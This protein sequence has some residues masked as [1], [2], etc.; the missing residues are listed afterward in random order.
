MLLK[1]SSVNQNVLFILSIQL[2]VTITVHYFSR[3]EKLR[4]FHG[5]SKTVVCVW[6]WD[7][8]W[9][10]NEA[11]QEHGPSCAKQNITRIKQIKNRERNR[12]LK[13]FRI[14]SSTKETHSIRSII[15]IQ[16]KSDQFIFLIHDANTYYLKLLLWNSFG[17]AWLDRQI[18]SIKMT[19]DLM[20]LPT[21]V[22]CQICILH[23]GSNIS[24]YKN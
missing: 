11:K 18:M 7:V 23:V 17:W 2:G 12:V 9:A 22:H 15:F 19:N 1:Y 4:I 14:S 13:Y 21:I 6:V 24:K 10:V 8:V 20:N 16:H 3:E 5:L